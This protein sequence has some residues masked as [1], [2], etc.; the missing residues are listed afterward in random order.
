[1]QIVW[2]QPYIILLITFVI[3]F[4]LHGIEHRSPHAKAALEHDL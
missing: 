3:I 4:L 1:M 2:D